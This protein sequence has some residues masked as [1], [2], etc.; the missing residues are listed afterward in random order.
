MIR[1]WV[2]EHPLRAG[3][4]WS[5]MLALALALTIVACVRRKGRTQRPASAWWPFAV[6]PI[7]VWL[8]EMPG[9]PE[10]IRD[11]SDPAEQ[12][13]FCA[14]AGTLRDDEGLADLA[15]RLGWAG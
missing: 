13:R 14:L 10:Q 15:E 2:I 3:L 8:E 1:Q 5:L 7:E 11:L 6:P 4:L 12:A 9:H